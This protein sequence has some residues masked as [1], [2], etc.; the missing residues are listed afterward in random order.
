MPTIVENIL[1]RHSIEGDKAEPK[2]IL[3]CRAD[4]ELS[5]EN[6]G[7]IIKKLRGRRPPEPEKIVIILDHRVPANSIKTA[8]TH[9]KI[10]EF[11]HSNGIDNFFDVS[12][13]ICHQVLAESKLVKPGGL[14]V[15][16]DSHTTTHG[17][18]G[19][20]ATGIGATEMASLWLTGKLWF[21]VPETMKINVS[22]K[23]KDWVT[24]KDIILKIIG[25]IGSDGANY[26]AIEFYGNTVDEMS[27]SSRMTMTNMAMEAG[28]KC[29][30]MPVD[31][32][33]AGYSSPGEITLAENA[34]YWK[35]MDYMVEDLEPMVACPDAV[36][37]VKNI[38]E[39]EGLPIDQGL[40]GSCTNGRVE[41]LEIAAGIL[42]N[43]R[44]NPGTRLL[45]LPA[46]R[47]IY[48]DCLR[49]G[50]VESLIESGAIILNPGCG[51][52][53]GAHEGI[54]ASG[55]VAITT[56][57]RNFKGRM[58]SPESKVYLANPAVVAASC[59][60]GKITDPRR[61]NSQY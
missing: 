38:R 19:A 12:Y 2:K 61:L 17:A 59:I 23:L 45:I 27:I 39:V 37:N 29:A 25:D 43:N 36:D 44:V 8:E 9:R 46:S 18:F 10:R 1:T 6:A 7:L 28:A 57:N 30:F 22:G 5:H 11:V 16:T 26:K 40:I 33:T 51:P 47:K 53:L 52:C 4:L 48:L 50:I 13:G 3:N 56:T 20:F 14:V 60:E 15:G 24:S 35:E 55:E 54:L 32:K 58:G 34:N 41:D 31:E 42:K 21:K 49:A